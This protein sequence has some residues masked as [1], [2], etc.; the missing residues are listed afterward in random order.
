MMIELLD[1]LNLL[2]GIAAFAFAVMWRRLD[3]LHKTLLERSDVM[4][5][6]E[7][8]IAVLEAGIQ[9]TYKFLEKIE[10]HL[11]RI[12]EKLDAKADK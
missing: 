2:W 8:R 12:E 11:E 9:S 10:G 5:S 7:T 3:G 1:F 6:H 4:H